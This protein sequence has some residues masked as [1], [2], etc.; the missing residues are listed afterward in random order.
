MILPCVRCATPN[1]WVAAIHCN[2]FAADVLG[3][4]L[5]F[6]YEDRQWQTDSCPANEWSKWWHILLT[7]DMFISS[8]IHNVPQR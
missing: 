8:H 6:E 4:F 2:S 1:E 3:A 7:Y 5:H